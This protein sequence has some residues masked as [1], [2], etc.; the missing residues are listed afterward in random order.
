M[1]AMRGRALAAA[2]V[3][4]AIGALTACAPG[5]I[6]CPA[7]GFVYGDPV[8]LQISPEL[9]G[10]GAA[11]ACLGEGCDV[12]EVVLDGDGRGEIPQEPPY[13]P[14][15]TIGIN[16]GDQVRVVITDGSGEIVRDEQVEIPYA[17]ESGG[18]CPAPVEFQ[19][20]IV[21]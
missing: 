6:A 20:V 1:I 15:D 18:L 21:S 2:V 14:A 13:F 10:D 12:A 7:I 9:L 11:L 3:C 8:V 16:P 19:P 4:A 17:S 5:G